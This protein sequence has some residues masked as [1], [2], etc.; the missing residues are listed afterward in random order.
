MS[1]PPRHTTFIWLGAA[2]HSTHCKHRR[3]TTYCNRTSR[4]RDGFT[5]GDLPIFSNRRELDGGIEQRQSPICV[6]AV[7]VRFGKINAFRRHSHAA[8]TSSISSAGQATTSEEK[9]QLASSRPDTFLSSPRSKAI[10]GRFR[11][12][13]HGFHPIRCSHV[14][15]LSATRYPLLSATHCPNLLRDLDLPSSN[16]VASFGTGT[17]S[18]YNLERE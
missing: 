13:G 3:S 14:F 8:T 6:G 4:I 17:V 1:A 18:V 16:P 7:R 10:K 11:V 15:V 9:S 2:G 5:V 12:E